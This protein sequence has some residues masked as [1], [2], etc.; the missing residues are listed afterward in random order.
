MQQAGTFETRRDFLLL[1]KSHSVGTCPLTV[2]IKPV[3][4]MK[5]FVGQ[6]TVNALT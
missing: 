6:E 2:G 3:W 4:H 1:P 5:V